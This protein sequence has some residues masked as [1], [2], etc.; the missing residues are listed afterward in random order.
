MAEIT[1]VE[2]TDSAT[3]LHFDVVFQPG[4]WIRVPPESHIREYGTNN[5][6]KLTKAVGIAPGEQFTMPDS[7]RT[8]YQLYFPPLAPEVTKIDFIECD[9]PDCWKIWGNGAGYSRPSLPG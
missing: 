4:N 9:H 7:G 6:L 3:I 2:T 8:A 1:K 5:I